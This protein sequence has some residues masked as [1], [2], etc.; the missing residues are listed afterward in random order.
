METAIEL[1]DA[2]WSPGMTVRLLGVG[3]SDFDQAEG[4]QMDFF[5]EVDERG[6]M[7][8]DKRDLSVALDR[9]R[10]RFGDA[11]VGSAGQ[12]GSAPGHP[13]AARVGALSA[14]VD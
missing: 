14:A 11:A 10:D 4:V 9:V 1:L 13:K 6:A 8:S 12:R 2:V 3:V 5:C 7:S